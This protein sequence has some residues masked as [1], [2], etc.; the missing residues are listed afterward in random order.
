LEPLTN[1]H[2]SIH[3]GH[4]ELYR[5][6]IYLTY[7]PFFLVA[8]AIENS[9]YLSVYPQLGGY[10]TLF[11]VTLRI[12]R[13]SWR[14]S[15]SPPCVS[16]FEL[17][18]NLRVG[19]HNPFTFHPC[20]WFTPHSVYSTGRTNPDSI[21]EVRAFLR[22]HLVSVRE[23]ERERVGTRLEFEVPKRSNTLRCCVPSPQLHLTRQFSRANRCERER[24]DL[25][26]RRGESECA[27][28]GQGYRGENFN[29]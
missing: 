11:I 2:L 13:V 3:K 15:N 20:A 21:F 26:A 28:R 4:G 5:V 23:R 25:R 7:I 8:L 24:I 27:I 17:R 6:H 9:H 19:A 18:V 14:K 10:T 1:P 22:G 16:I 29:V 12:C